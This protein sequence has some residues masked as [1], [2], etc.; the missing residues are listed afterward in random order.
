VF[1]NLLN[2]AFYPLHCF[3]YACPFNFS[4]SLSMREGHL[5]VKVHSAKLQETP[6]VEGA[7]YVSA[8]LPQCGRHSTRHAQ[9]SSNPTFEQELKFESRGSADAQ[10]RRAGGHSCP[11]LPPA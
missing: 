7:V 10:V 9:T 4:N 2:C 8:E 3:F 11:S 5:Q 6:S 1:T